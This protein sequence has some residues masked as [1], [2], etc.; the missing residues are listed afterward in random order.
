M[1]VGENIWQ[2]FFSDALISPPCPYL[3]GFNASYKRQT[4]ASERMALGEILLNSYQH[5]ICCV[6]NMHVGAYLRSY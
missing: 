6:L 2:I 1:T 4:S 3:Q 5:I